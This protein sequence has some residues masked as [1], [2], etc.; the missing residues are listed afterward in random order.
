MALRDTS[1]GDS[2]AAHLEQVPGLEGVASGE[3]SRLDENLHYG[4]AWHRYGYCYRAIE[5]GRP[6]VLDVACGSGRTSVEAAR[7][8]PQGSVLGVDASPAAV[9]FARER[10]EPAGLEAPI[11]FRVHDPATPF[12]DSWGT[13]DFVVCRGLRA[14]L[15]DTFHVLANVAR[16]LD[17]AGLLLLCLPSRHGRATHHA[18]CRAVDVLA[19]ECESLPERV[20][21]GL[22]LFRSLRPDHPMRAHAASADDN[23]ERFVMEALTP[24][25][26]WTLEEA[27]QL[28]TRAGL[29]FLYAATPWRWRPERVFSFEGKPE[30]FRVEGLRPA[31]LSQVIDALDP[32]F[33]GTDYF[34]YSCPAGHE[35]S[36]PD[37]PNTFREE[38][39]ALA[40]LVPH[41][42]GLA[43]LVPAL[44]AFSQSRVSYR[45]VT[46]SIGELDRC[47]GLL[48]SAV[49]GRKTC[50]AIESQFADQIRA[51]D[52][53]TARQERWIDLADHGLIFL[54][55]SDSS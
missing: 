27:V 47:A 15:A 35:P 5:P 31:S 11:E 55:P 2:Q 43:H 50:A 40:R 46:G 17:P 41:L 29:K 45:T 51:S 20:S 32:F 9:S 44:P 39:G 49:D 14:G 52:G 23:S 19:P 21:V 8:N 42:S 53:A 22:E 25:S 54:D 1:S 12:P 37:W 13:F 16:T 36:I 7:L 33:L 18:L 48:L 4:R 34:L 10:A 26:D 38:P 28:L 6:R 30:R 3:P 24:R